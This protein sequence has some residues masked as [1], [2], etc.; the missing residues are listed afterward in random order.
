MEDINRSEGSFRV[1]WE[2][3]PGD[4]EHV[5]REIGQED[6]DPS[7]FTPGSPVS[8]DDFPIIP[9]PYLSAPGESLDRLW[10]QTT[11]KINYQSS[12]WYDAYEP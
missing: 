12:E 6:M 7:L 10:T 2:I 8:S 11:I 4:S 3:L 5:F 1:I 9:Y